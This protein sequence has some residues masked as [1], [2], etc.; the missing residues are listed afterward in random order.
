MGA[1]TTTESQHAKSCGFEQE[2]I[3]VFINRDIFFWVREND[4]EMPKGDL[5]VMFGMEHN[6]KDDCLNGDFNMFEQ[7]IGQRH[8]SVEIVTN[9][10]GDHTDLC[11]DYLIHPDKPVSVNS[12]R[13]LCGVLGLIEDQRL[14]TCGW[15]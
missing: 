11:E 9:L 1:F 7:I 6:I 15:G 14:D 5:I 10:C 8:M 2:D 3:D 4:P 13:S 12:I